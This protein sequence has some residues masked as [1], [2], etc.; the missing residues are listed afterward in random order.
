[1]PDPGLS[2]AEKARIREEEHY[3]AQIRAE[4]QEHPSTPK[5]RPSYWAGLLLNLVI[6]GVGFMTIGEWGLGLLWLFAG[7][8]LSLMSGGTLW[9]V[10]VIVM[11]V[12]YNGT[13]V[14]K[15]GVVFGP[16]NIK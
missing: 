12:H 11:L 6:L 7:G 16:K 5:P 8:A 1:M 4:L 10:V 3:R 15:Y 9:P 14:R 2:D 13:Y